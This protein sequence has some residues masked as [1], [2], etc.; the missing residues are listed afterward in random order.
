MGV[1]AGRWPAE[2]EVA[3]GVVLRSPDPVDAEA[4][5][6]AINQSLDHLRGFMVWAAEAAT[7][8]QQATRL[9][10]AAEDFS[11]GGDAHYTM[12]LGDD[13]IGGLGL[14]RRQ[15]P[16]ALEVGYWI[17][18]DHEGRGIMTSAVRAVLP[19]AFDVDGATRVVIR[20]DEAN[21]RSAAIAQRLGFVRLGV[22]TFE[23]EA[24][25]QSGRMLVWELSKPE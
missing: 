25:A 20:C 12:F 23:V 10:L 16:G 18:A 21:A 3:G 2:I 17:R 24:P 19:V 22:Q 6:A 11:A 9:A 7:V 14:H 1:T 8:E 13:V 5:T 15:G 4:V